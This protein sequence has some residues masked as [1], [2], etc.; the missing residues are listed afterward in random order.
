MARTYTLRKMYTDFSPIDNLK[1]EDAIETMYLQT[2]HGI[3]YL[4]TN[5]PEDEVLLCAIREVK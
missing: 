2:K 4:T 3:Y 1:L 5:L